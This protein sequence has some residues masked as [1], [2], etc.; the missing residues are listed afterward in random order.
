MQRKGNQSGALQEQI[1]AQRGQTGAQNGVSRRALQQPNQHH[2]HEE[3]EAPA[4]LL[5]VNPF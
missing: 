5:Q 2:H 1:C 4:V 3:C